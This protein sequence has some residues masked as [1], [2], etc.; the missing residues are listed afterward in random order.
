[1][2]QAINDNKNNDIPVV[3]HRK[4]YGEWLITMKAKDWFN[5]YKAWINS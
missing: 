1:M 3:A 5:L 4:N 2:D